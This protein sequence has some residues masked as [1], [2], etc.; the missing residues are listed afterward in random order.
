M[1][2]VGSDEGAIM[3]EKQRHPEYC[4]FETH[5]KNTLHEICED[6]KALRQKVFNGLSDLPEEIRWIRRLLFGALISA[7]LTLGATA[8]TS[9][10]QSSRLEALLEKTSQI[11]QEVTDGPV[12]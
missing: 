5:Y 4:V 7:I 1:S 9:M 3:V 12:R 10:Q 8:W 6:V 11:R 2:D